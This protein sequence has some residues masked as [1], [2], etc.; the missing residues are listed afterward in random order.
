MSDTTQ[1]TAADAGQHP[2]QPPERTPELTSELLRSLRDGRLPDQPQGDAPMMPDE[3]VADEPAPEPDPLQQAVT[4]LAD[5]VRELDGETAGIRE[6]V[7]QNTQQVTEILSRFATGIQ[8]QLSQIELTP[9]PQGADGRDGEDGEAGPPGARGPRG[10]RGHAGPQGA[11]GPRGAEG[12]PGPAGPAGSNATLPTDG[13]SVGSVVL[14]RFFGRGGSYPNGFIFRPLA[15]GRP[16]LEHVGFDFGGRPFNLGQG[17]RI[18]HGEW[19][20]LYQGRHNTAVWSNGLTGLF[21]RVA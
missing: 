21:V 3:P 18:T 15:D 12:A 8:Q 1:D 5:R 19:R 9:G 7:Q 14:A 11:R 16:S 17:N 13:L 2:G 20:C 10:P 6:L 4:A